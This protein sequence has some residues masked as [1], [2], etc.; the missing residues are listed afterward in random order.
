MTEGSSMTTQPGS[1]VY[2][3]N[4]T[5]A[6]TLGKENTA[7][8]NTVGKAMTVKDNSLAYNNT[9]GELKVTAKNSIVKNNQINGAVNIAKA[10]TNTTFANNTAKGTVTVLSNNNV[11]TGNMIETTGDYAI[12]LKTTENNT[13]KNNILIANNKT[14][15]DAVNGNMSK[16]NAEGNADK[17][18]IITLITP[19]TVAAGEAF[20]IKV[21]VQMTLET[22]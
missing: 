2:N 11:I 3:N 1:I 12:D 6:L 5:G 21:S 14:G 18:A 4:V 16:N 19:E 9:V 22:H 20:T 17:K 15:N 10:A 8:N 13:I 7:Y